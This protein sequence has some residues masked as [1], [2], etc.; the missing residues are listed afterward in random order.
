MI[1][2]SRVLSLVA[3]IC[4]LPVA[5]SS[6]RAEAAPAS[7]AVLAGI[8]TPPSS[9][10]DLPGG[11]YVQKVDV[12]LVVLH[13]TVLDHHGDPVFGLQP[14]DFQVR[15]DGAVR[16]VSVF[17]SSVDQPVRVAFLLDVS[18]SM[19]LLS[20]L[21]RAKEAIRT[22][23][24]SLLPQ[25]QIALLIFADGQV[26][27]KLGFTADRRALR[28]TLDG[29]EAYGRTAL[30]NALAE[31]PFL[32]SATEPGR[33]ALVIL[34]DGLDNA[35]TVTPQEAI[36]MARRAPVPIFAIGLADLPLDIRPG[37]TEPGKGVSLFETL[38]DFTRGTGGDFMAVYSPVEIQAAVDL[39]DH[40]LRGQ[41]IVGYV[42]GPSGDIP[43]NHRIDVTTRNRRHQ[44]LTRKGYYTS[45]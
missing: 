13:V 6:L 28:E 3:L 36:E 11:G 16:K 27:V 12:S 30:Q 15:E 21:D 34:T 44:V 1:S 32:L 22:F 4:I 35:S 2:I 19:K 10:S 7:P 39:L 25:D 45:P 31:A 40:R 5:S 18:G 9:S 43:G 42:P 8:T 37:K 17:G 29:I 20:K 14:R 26:V 24:A 38:E 41:Y 33:K 23:A